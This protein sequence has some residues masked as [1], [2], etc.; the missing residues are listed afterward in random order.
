MALTRAYEDVRYG[1]LGV[2]RSVLQA[3]DEGRTN[4]MESLQRLSRAGMPE[5]P[6]VSP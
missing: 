3:L 1:N 2:E 4:L 5:E 6:S